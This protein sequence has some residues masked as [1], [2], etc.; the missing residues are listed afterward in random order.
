MELA[1]TMVFAYATTTG[2][3]DFHMTAETVLKEFVLTS[4]RGLM[5]LIKWDDD[6]NMRNVLEEEF[7]TG[8]MGNALAFQDTKEKHVKDPLVRMIAVAMEDVLLLRI[9]V[10]RQRV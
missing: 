8:Q 1:V 10:N 6:T 4:L 2:A 9:K 7:V 3:W 5:L